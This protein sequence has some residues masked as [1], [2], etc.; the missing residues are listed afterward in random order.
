MALSMAFFTVIHA[1]QIWWHSLKTSLPNWTAIA[2]SMSLISISQKPLIR[3]HIL[4]WFRSRVIMESKGKFWLEQSSGWGAGRHQR[5]CV[6]GA[7]SGWKE[8]LSGVTQ[9]SNLSL[10]LFLIFNNDLD[11]DMI[12]KILKFADDIKLYGR[13][14]NLEDHCSLQNDL[15][16]LVWWSE[17]WLMEFNVYKCRVMHTGMNNP[18]YIY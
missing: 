10:L 15:D 7:S 1:E 5:V 11:H 4:A 2:M 18:N 8:I 13:V 16:Q 17:K 9:G 3:C 14:S 6:R 12:N